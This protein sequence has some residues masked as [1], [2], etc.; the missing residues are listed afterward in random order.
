MVRQISLVSTFRPRRSRWIS[1]RCRLR[2]WVVLLALWPEGTLR[3][4]GTWKLV[5]PRLALASR[6]VAV[7]TTL[8]TVMGRI[9]TACCGAAGNTDATC[10]APKSGKTGEADGTTLPSNDSSAGRNSGRK[11]AGREGSV[12]R[13]ILGAR[14][15]PTSAN[16]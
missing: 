16:M 5:L 14:K 13:V 3:V 1:P 9:E 12:R 2:I 15:N 7:L 11:G 4:S 8:L 6:P 10:A